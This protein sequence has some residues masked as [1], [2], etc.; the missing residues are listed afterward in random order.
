MPVGV[1]DVWRLQI[2]GTCFSQRIR[3]T[4]G[5]IVTATVAPPS[6]STF[7]DF[8]LNHV[9][10]GVGGTDILETLYRDLMPTSY[11]LDYWEVQQIRPIRF[12]Y[13]RATRAVP[14]LHADDTNA[15][16]QAVAL[17]LKSEYAGRWAQSNKHIGPIP[18]SAAVQQDGEITA[19]Y[20]AKVELFGAAL[21]TP[22]TVAGVTLQPCIIHPEGEHLGTTP[23]LTQ[24]QQLTLRT[25][26]R[27][28][29]RVGE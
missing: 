16:N 8:F 11:I 13:G 1:N 29:V 4:H 12:A 15:T 3:F 17:T 20:K 25:M 10:G 5:Y 23:L 2:A 24:V 7:R 26:R 22:L 18:Q 19:A 27:R 6:E 9:R 21:L 14:G 28:T